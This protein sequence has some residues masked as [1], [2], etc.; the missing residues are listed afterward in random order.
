MTLCTNKTIQTLSIIKKSPT[1]V[2]NI[3]VHI[4]NNPANKI[5]PTK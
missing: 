2:E 1:F 3:D 5:N 4:Q